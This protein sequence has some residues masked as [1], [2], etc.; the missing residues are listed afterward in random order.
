MDPMFWSKK[1]Q[2]T[3]SLVGSK[4]VKGAPGG[5]TASPVTAKSEALRAQA[6]A[7]M[8]AAREEIGEETL[9]KIAA[10]IARK[11]NSVSEKAKAQIQKADPDK[12]ASELLWMLGRRD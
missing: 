3:A 6:L 5:K 11:E 12:V 1:K 9:Q 8:R 2:K 10:A 4:T 7:T